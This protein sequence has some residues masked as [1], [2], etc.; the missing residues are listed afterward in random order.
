MA[1][2]ARSQD[3]LELE[4]RFWDA[5]KSKDSRAASRLTDDQCIVV[6]A[7]G[8]SSIDRKTMGKMTE[9]TQWHLDRFNVDDTSAQVRFINDDVALVAYK[10]N[11]RVTVEGKPVEL[12]A[13][14]ASVWVR[15]D[16]EWRCAMHTESIAGD[17]YGRDR[18]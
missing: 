13:N 11:E 4:R 18:H 16:G 3:L 6:G 10:V 8:V 15:R 14:D 12:D 17:P 9:D 7:Q 1:T 2:T 5:M